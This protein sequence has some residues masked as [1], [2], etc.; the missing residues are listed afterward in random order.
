VGFWKRLLTTDEVATLYNSGDG[1][2]YPFYI[3]GTYDPPQYIPSTAQLGRSRPTYDGQSK[4]MTYNLIPAFLSSSSY[5]M[6]DSTYTLACNQKYAIPENVSNNDVVGTWLKTWTWM[7]NNAIIYSIEN[8]PVS[9]FAINSSTGVITIS[10][11]SKINGKIVTQDTV[12]NLRIRTTDMIEGYEIDTAVIRVKENSYCKFY[13]Y[14][15]SGTESGTRTQPY[16]DLDDVASAPGYGY[17]LKRGNVAFGEGTLF[18]THLTSAS[19]PTIVGSYGTGDDFVFDGTG[20]SG[21]CFFF[22][23]NG[24][25]DRELDRADYVELYNLEIFD[26]TYIAIEVYRKSRNL[27]FYNL[28]MHNNDKNSVQS[29]FVINTQSYADSITNMPIELINC[30]FDTVGYLTDYEPSLVKCGSSPFYV[31][32][33]RFGKSIHDALRITSG[34]LGATVK[35]SYFDMGFT[36]ATEGYNNIQVRGHNTTVEDCRF[37]GGGG[38]VYMTAAAGAYYQQPDNVTVRNCYFRG[39]GNTSIWMRPPSNTY[40]PSYDHVYENNY[41]LTNGRGINYRDANNLT[42]RR[43]VIIGLVTPAVSEGIINSEADVNPNIYYNIISNFSYGI[44]FNVGAGSEIYNNTVT[45]GIYLLGS[46][47]ETVRNNFYSSLTSATTASNNIDVDDIV[48][49]TYFEDYDNNNFKLIN[50]AMDAINSGYNV[51]LTPDIIGT[52]VPQGSAP[53]IGAYEYNP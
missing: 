53:D 32:N 15:Y 5:Y 13:D 16:N 33:C 23:E 21:H 43:N 22:G 6:Y 4:Y 44:Y 26:Y 19:H 39:Q 31:T 1:L 46:G 20:A 36:T 47:T 42:I 10:D 35:H 48:Q 52:I 50:T 37:I 49:T 12:I 17:F 11:A 27:G 14:A 24:E 41:I 38:G 18:K 3:P 30:E 40:N 51:S 45:N 25:G 8:D 7:S 34:S 9:A 28:K 29:N 2:T